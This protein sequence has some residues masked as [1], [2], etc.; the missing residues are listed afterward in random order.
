MSDEA[1][2]GVQIVSPSGERRG[3]EIL[4][5]RDHFAGLAMQVVL[6]SAGWTPPALVDTAM[7]SY[8]VADAMLKA[9]DAK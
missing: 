5:L 2:F 9:R 6:R 3:L 1:N 8:R 7:F 4:S